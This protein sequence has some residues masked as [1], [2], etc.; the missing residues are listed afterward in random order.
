[1]KKISCFLLVL[2]AAGCSYATDDKRL[3]SIQLEVASDSGMPINN[4]HVGYENEEIVAEQDGGVFASHR[5][6]VSDMSI[7]EYALVNWKLSDGREIKYKVPIRSQIMNADLFK[8]C[9]AFYINDDSLVVLTSE[10]LPILSDNINATPPKKINYIFEADSNLIG[11]PI[12]AGEKV[13][14]R[15]NSEK[16]L[17]PCG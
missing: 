13:A 6:I 17:P 14:A 2:L 10:Y 15:I 12:K 16:N 1:M 9:V 7:P 3:H 5:G 11:K 4:V 8:G